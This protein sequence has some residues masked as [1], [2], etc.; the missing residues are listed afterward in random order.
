[1]SNFVDVV[2]EASKLTADEQESLIEILRR[3]IA[4]RNREE[5][6]REIQQARD[7]HAS[8]K[9]KTTTVTNLMNEITSE[10]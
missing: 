9:S 6:E 1:M 7:E 8:G 2:E 4:A 10:S 3:R 5:I